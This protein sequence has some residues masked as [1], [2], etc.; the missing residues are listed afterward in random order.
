MKTFIMI[1]TYNEKENIASLIKEILSLNI[2]DI[3]IVV[4]DDNS[5]DET[6]KIVEDISKKD[7]RVHLLLRKENRGRGYAGRA[8]YKYSLEHAADYIIEM[9]ADLSHNP[10]Y[11]PRLLEKVK[12]ADLAIGSRRI[13]GGKEEGRGLVRKIITIFANLYIR[14]MLGLKVK[15]CNSGFRCFRRKVL[16]TINVDK[17]TSKGPSIVQE[18]LFKAKL[19]G[20]RIEE[21]PIVFKD[22]ELGKSKLGLKQLAAGYWMVL[23]LKVMHLFG[24]I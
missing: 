8:G 24:A 3:E 16:E 10:C 6:W 15:D 13:K 12:E 1:P 20:F 17:L 21:V 18:V 5:P 7:K 4:V 14:I 2:K 11:I 23:K 19:K 22:R 9:D